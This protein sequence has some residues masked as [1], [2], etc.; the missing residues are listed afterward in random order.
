MSYTGLLNQEITLYNKSSYDEYGREVVGSGST[1][2]CRFQR[3]TKRKLLENGN[4]IEIMA[5]CYIANDVIVATDDK[6][7]FGSTDYKVLGRYDA[8]DGA[9]NTHHIKLELIKWQS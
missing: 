2:K 6:V 4:L 3:T 1:V 9:G 7:T 5:I 8:V